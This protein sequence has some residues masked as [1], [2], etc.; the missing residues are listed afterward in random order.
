MKIR[1]K[2]NSVRFRLDKLDLQLLEENG[3]V[4]EKTEFPSSTFIYSVLSSRNEEIESDFKSNRIE[5]RLPETLI[6][7]WINSD[8]VGFE[9]NEGSLKILI[10]KDFQCLTPREEE[11]DLNTFPNPLEKHTC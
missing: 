3:R 11:D 10:E 1:I 8:Q 9:N 4:D 6:Q 5:L 7:K 2:G